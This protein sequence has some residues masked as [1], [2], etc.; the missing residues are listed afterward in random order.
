MIAA[1]AANTM[2]QMVAKEC[3]TVVADSWD[4]IMQCSYDMAGTGVCSVVY[5]AVEKILLHLL[6]SE[7]M[8]KTV[9][10]HIANNFDTANS[11][12]KIYGNLQSTNAYI[13]S[14]VV[15]MKQEVSEA[16][17]AV[18]IASKVPDS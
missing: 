6:R 17:L 3:S 14:I 12:D 1:Q 15:F 9:D 4:D 2:K 8:N 11:V 10:K 16:F 5:N 18:H 13:A 7:M